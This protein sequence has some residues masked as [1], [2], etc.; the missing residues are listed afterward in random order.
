M[1]SRTVIFVEMGKPL[2]VEDIE[3]DD[4]VAPGHVLVHKLRERRLPLPA[5]RPARSHQPG[6]ARRARP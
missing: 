1:K 5:A 2:L 3:Y 6:A 4:E